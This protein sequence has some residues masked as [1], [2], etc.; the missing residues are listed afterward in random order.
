MYKKIFCKIPAAWTGLFALLAGVAQ[1]A[2]PHNDDW[3]GRTVIDGLPF[4]DTVEDVQTATNEPS[5]PELFCNGGEAPSRGADTLWYEYTTGV[6]EEYVDIDAVGYSTIVA[7]FEGSPAEGYE[8]VRGGCSDGYTGGQIFNSRIVGLRLKPHTR[9]A[10]EAAAFMTSVFPTMRLGFRVTPA[11]VYRVTKTEDTNDGACDADCSLRE[12]V[13]AANATEGAIV[14]PTGRYVLTSQLEAV[15]S[16]SIYGAGMNETVIDA[17][18]TG[19]VLAHTT[20]DQDSYALHD[21]TLTGGLAS[22]DGGAFIGLAAG[23]Y[24]FDRVALRDSQGANGGGASLSSVATT[25]SMFDS[26]VSGNVAK[27]D[28]GGVYF[29]GINIELVNTS[30]V[31]NAAAND[32]GGNGGGIYLKPVYAGRLKNATISDNHAKGLAGGV[33]VDIGSAWMALAINNSS[34][35]NNAAGGAA[36]PQNG[37]LVFSGNPTIVAPVVTN[38]VL[39]G[40]YATQKPDALADCGKPANVVLKTGYDFVQSPNGCAFDATGDKT[41]A[42]PQLGPLTTD[43]AVPVHVPTEGSPLIDAGDP[44]AGCERDD[45]RGVPRPVD[46]DADG[47]P[48]CDIGAVEWTTLNRSDVIFADGFE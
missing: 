34:V 12:A 48:F 29:D 8:M 11:A 43:F 7:V 31:G 45:A 9:Y 16:G 26:V 1:A 13:D 18:G 25:V 2:G 32:A 15:R 46:G 27:G 17:A 36:S 47:K 24:V 6:S 39:A 33:H 28:G 42:D 35:V 44:A 3:A 21:L 5:D 41:A 19:R 30:L 23:H 10:I 40:N 22:G 37:G 38:T 4:V 14:V 20:F